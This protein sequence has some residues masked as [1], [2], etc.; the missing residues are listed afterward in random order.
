MA[1]KSHLFSVAQFHR[2]IHK[3]NTDEVRQLSSRIDTRDE[4]IDDRAINLQVHNNLQETESGLN[5]LSQL[6]RDSDF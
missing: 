4:R 3:V 6:Q 5:V 1:L 2:Y